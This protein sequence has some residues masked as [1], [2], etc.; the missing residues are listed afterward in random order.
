MAHWHRIPKA[1]RDAFR[2]DRRAWYEHVTGESFEGV[3]LSQSSG[4]ER[5]CL[6]V[7]GV[8]TTMGNLQPG[9]QS[10]SQAPQKPVSAKM[11][12]VRPQPMPM[13]M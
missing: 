6:R 3:N 9:K 8:L 1:M 2:K 5:T 12:R 4:N 10:H 7:D 11:H 13:R